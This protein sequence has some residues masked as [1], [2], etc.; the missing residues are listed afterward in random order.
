MKLIGSTG[1]ECTSMTVEGSQ[2]PKPEFTITDSEG[3]VVE[4]GSFEYG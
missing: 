4:S 1:E 2:P 3:K